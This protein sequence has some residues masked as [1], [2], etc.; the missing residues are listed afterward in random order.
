[1]K[2]T[3]NKRIAQ[4]KTDYKKARALKIIFEAEQVRCDA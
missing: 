2:E 4:G 3:D 1:M